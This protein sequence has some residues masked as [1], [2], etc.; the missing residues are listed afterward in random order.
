M[1]PTRNK[2]SNDWKLYDLHIH[3]KWSKDSPADPKLVVRIAI[4]KGLAGIAI[5]DHNHILGAYDAKKHAPEGFNVIIGEEI[6]TKQG[7]VIGLNISERIKPKIDLKETIDQIREQ[8]GIVLLP[9][10]ISVFRR[11]ICRGKML[12]IAKM[13]D[14]VEVVNGRSF[15]FDNLLS[16]K[17]A[18]EAKK[19]GVGGSDAHFYFEIGSVTVDLS[20]GFLKP[21]PIIEKQ[22]RF[23]IFPALLSGLVN[24]TKSRRILL[25]DLINLNKSSPRA[26]LFVSEDGLLWSGAPKET[27]KVLRLKIAGNSLLLD[28]EYS[29]D[30]ETVSFS[31]ELHGSKMLVFP[32]GEKRA[33][34]L[35]VDDVIINNRSEVTHIVLKDHTIIP[36]PKF[37]RLLRGGINEV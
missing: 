32:R 16:M 20:R 5:T 37:I 7:D 19:P 29:R 36:L 8:G 2:N 10:P 4:K 25:K 13:V 26:I 15:S 6:K 24:L 35:L 11:R 22:F 33:S 30:I 27:S 18:E 23:R 3:T 28:E 12:S 31:L 9:H 14:L 34:G 1:E 17:L 21:G